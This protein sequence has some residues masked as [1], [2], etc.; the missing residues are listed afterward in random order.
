MW[1]S[2]VCSCDEFDI[3]LAW[4]GY[5]FLFERMRH[6]AS[7]S[8]LSPAVLAQSILNDK[9]D[10]LQVLSFLVLRSGCMHAWLANYFGNQFMRTIFPPRFN[11]GCCPF[12][13]GLHVKLFLKVSYVHL[14]IVLAN[15]IGRCGHLVFD[16]LYQLIKEHRLRRPLFCMIPLTSIKMF[17]VQN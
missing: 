11:Y 6:F 5:S 8:N 2:T 3:W 13:F 9:A 1:S 17:H 4:A 7:E 16:S 10:I 15:I 12:C 14:K